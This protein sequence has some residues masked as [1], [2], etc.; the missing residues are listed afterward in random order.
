MHISC[1]ILI[2]DVLFEVT[3]VPIL[4]INLQ[5]FKNRAA[6][7][8]LD[9]DFSTPSAF[10]F[11]ELKWMPF[12]DRVIYQKAL[13]MY[14]TIHGGAPEYLSTPFTFTSEI[15]SRILRYTCSLK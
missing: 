15:N 5:K 12:P 3:A 1:L 10:L 7:L 6:R 11:S 13:Q 4:K 14:K 8:F 9:R 2:T